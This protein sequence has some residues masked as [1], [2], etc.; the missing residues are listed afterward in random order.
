MKKSS[1]VALVMGT[2]STMLFGIGMCM[3]LLAEWNAFKQ[4]I[5]VGAAGLVLGLVTVAVWRKMENK[6]KVKISAKTA[7]TVLY[8]VAAA[9][10]FGFGMCQ[11]LVWE[12][13][14]KGIILGI[15]GIVMFLGLIP[16]T[17]GLK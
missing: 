5:A 6:P 10:V 3:A 8:I 17:K 14:V 2:V 7:L 11:C 4:G 15:A 13:F 16:M 1:F 12:E 9:I